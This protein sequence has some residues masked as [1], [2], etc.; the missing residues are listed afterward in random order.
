VGNSGGKFL[1]EETDGKVVVSL[2]RGAR[3]SDWRCRELPVLPIGS[4]R[5]G[6]GTRVLTHLLGSPMPGAILGAP[7]RAVFGPESKICADCVLGGVLGSTGG[8][9]LS[10]NIP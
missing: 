4:C 8:D 10:P 6:A 7:V 9:A 5:T 1:A 2:P 3:V